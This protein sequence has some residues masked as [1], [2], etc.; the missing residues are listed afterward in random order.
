MT[1]LKVISDTKG[2]FVYKDHLPLLG[3]TNNQINY[4]QTGDLVTIDLDMEIV[5]SLQEDHG[6]WTDDML[7][8]FT[9]TG[10]VVNK[11]ENNDVI[12]A[13]TSGKQWTFNPAVL[14][15][16]SNTQNLN[17][18]SN[19]DNVHSILNSTNDTGSVSLNDPFD[20]P[21]TS[22]L[23]NSSTT[24]LNINSIPNNSQH[25]N[26][27]N[28]LSNQTSVNQSLSQQSNAQ[29]FAVGDLVRISSNLER[30]KRLQQHHGEWSE[31]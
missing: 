18:D 3:E 25:L 27:N 7:E 28:E 6:S 20:Q 17:L 14:T 11:T 29:E 21:S 4:F 2:Y 26:S 19:Y 23:M 12:V 24:F 13:Y 30:I 8:C 9:L 15:K 5:K 31:V 22:G 16:F 10:K 1:D